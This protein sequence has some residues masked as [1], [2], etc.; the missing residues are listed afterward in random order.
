[1]SDVDS[2]DDGRFYSIRVSN[3]LGTAVSDEA[4]LTV[5]A[6]VI[7]PTLVSAVAVND[8]RVDITF[9]EPVS[10]SSA[11]TSSNYQINLGITVNAVNLS[12][13]GRTVNLT[14]SQLN[15]ETT[16]TVS[17]SNVQDRA[18]SSNSILALSETTFSY[19]DGYDFEEGN[20]EGWSPRITDA[21]R[22]SVGPDKGDMA[23]YINDGSF[24]SLDG[25]RLGTYSLLAGD[26]GDFTFT[27]QARLGA[28]VNTAANADYALVF[29]Y[30]DAENYYYVMFNNNPDYTQL[31]KV[32]EG[33]RGTALASAS[34]D[35]L[36]DNAYH[37]I[38]VSRA[39]SV[40]IVLFD[41]EEVLRA[42]DNSQI[43]GRVGVGS[44]ND[45]AY[46]DEV[47]VTGAVVTVP[48]TN[49]PSTPSTPRVTITTN[50]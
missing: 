43:T 16:Y 33:T 14:V 4:M 39:G 8:T 3:D 6:D 18:Q 7:A 50:H 27:A 10:T 11:E 49:P 48:G 1:V 28:D 41:G 30:R 40:I 5:Q 21:G 19:R 24:N 17:V 25:G 47:S 46:F 34:K 37:G 32:S 26:Y 35:W 22:W 45:S 36:I 29:G 38:E 20:A 44:F 9:S 12:D 13:D 2:S 31:F 23:Y 15:Q 42:T